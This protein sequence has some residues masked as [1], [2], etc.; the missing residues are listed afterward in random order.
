MPLPKIADARKL[1]DRE[2]ADEI[3]AVKKQLFE[4]RLKKATSR[5]E[6]PHEF[7]HARHR[8]AQMLTVERERKIQAI[9][10]KTQAPEE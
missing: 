1:D 5:L 7:R 8:L 4:L 10:S 3:L 6:K 2:L 9:E